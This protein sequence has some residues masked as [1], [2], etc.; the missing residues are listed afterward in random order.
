MRI[1]F[2]DE[3]LMGDVKGTERLS[4]VLGYR[5]EGLTFREIGAFFGVG[6]QYAYQLFEKAERMER[7]GKLT[8]WTWSG[9]RPA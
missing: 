1:D 4:L 2:S 6:R 9:G 8:P 5:R 7:A 3:P